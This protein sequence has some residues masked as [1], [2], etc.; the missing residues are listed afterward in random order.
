LSKRRT[1]RL[2]VAPHNATLRWT[3]VFTEAASAALLVT[4]LPV[5]PVYLALAGIVI[6]NQLRSLLTLELDERHGAV[7]YI[8][9]RRGG[10]EHSQR[11]EMVLPEVNAELRRLHKPKM[12]E[13]E[14]RQKLDELSELGCLTPT[15]LGWRLKDKIW[16]T[17]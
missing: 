16:L 7:I 10:H 14:L 4:T 6:V 15:L 8:M 3:T 12:G 9:W 17:A 1:A 13:R 11:L 5:S 2:L